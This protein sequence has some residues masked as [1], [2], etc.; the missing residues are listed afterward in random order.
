[1]KITQ[2]SVFLKNSKGTLYG[3]C[4]LLGK[5]GI[6]INAIT[7][8]ENLEFGAVRLLVDK[9]EEAI[10]LL[11]D[12]N[13]IANT[14]EVVVAET[15]DNAGSLAGIL[16]TLF[17]NSINVD[18]MYGL[19]EKSSKKGLLVFKFDDTDKAIEIFAK[20]KVK[21]LGKKEINGI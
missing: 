18:Y 6:N 3:L 15:G 7:I 4:N 17:E 14:T 13:F 19:A 12:N 2:L 16:K 21:M 9:T 1:M 11:K 10:K 8:S 5:N 20:S